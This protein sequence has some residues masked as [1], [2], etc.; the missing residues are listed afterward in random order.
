MDRSITLNGRTYPYTV[1][2]PRTYDASH[3]WPVILSLHGAGE[4]GNDGV[5][6]MQIGAAQA[7]RATPEKVPAIVV[8]P[9]APADTRWIG[10]P[11]DA[12]LA[13]LEEA[14][15]E[16]RGDRDRLYLTGLSMGGYGTLHLGL[17][18]P[19]RFAALVVVCGGLFPHPATTA[20]QLS[21][22]VTDANDPYGLV[23]RSLRHLPI[24]FFH[25]DVD[26][27]IPVDE[28]RK[29][30]AALRATNAPDVRYTEYAGVGHNAW[31][32][33]YREA[34]LWT[35]LF[36][37]K[38]K[39]VRLPAMAHATGSFE[40]KLTPQDGAGDVGR[41]SIDKQFNG[42]LTGTSKGEMLAAMTKTEGSAG[43]VAIERVSATLQGRRG[44]FLLQHNG[45]MDRGQGT[46]VIN[47]IPDSGTEGL[48]GIAGTMKIDITGGKHLYTFDYTLP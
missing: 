32:R 3:T 28:S 8:F 35:W 13:A 7:V 45:L 41:M 47:V 15:V 4:R 43:Y 29:L 22:L 34:D 39:P 40:V 2:V 44:T 23:A 37:Q 27:V 5:R 33:A 17:Q 31:D 11:A 9:Q 25:G 42:D 1:Y 12:A 30:V 20:V 21:P 36:A 38:R 19:D 24:W 10:E 6:Q 16:F 48:V 18:H 14:I 46:L 26:P